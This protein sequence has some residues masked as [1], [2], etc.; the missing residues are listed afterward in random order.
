MVLSLD[1][2][3]NELLMDSRAISLENPVFSLPPLPRTS[4]EVSK[5][6]NDK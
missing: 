5:R 2:L 6:H 3:V 4:L 1:T